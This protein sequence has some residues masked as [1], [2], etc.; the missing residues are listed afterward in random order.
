MA[1]DPRD[2]SLD[3]FAEDIGW[4]ATEWYRVDDRVPATVLGGPAVAGA[5]VALAAPPV[6]APSP[7]AL[8]PADDSGVAGDGVTNVNRPR[9]TGTATAGTTVQLVSPAGAVLGSAAV[10]ADG[11]YSVAP[12]APL[13]DGTYSLLA[14]DVDPSGAASAPSAPGLH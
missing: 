6:A 5:T 12:S 7:P 9:F 10:A 11:S 13:A 2:G 8:L 3:V 14:R 1:R 4:S